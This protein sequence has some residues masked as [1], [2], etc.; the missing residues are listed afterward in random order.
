M[1]NIVI[2]KK[3]HINS[4]QTS[5]NYIN[6]ILCDYIDD[7]KFEHIKLNY[8]TVIFLLKGKMQIHYVNKTSEEVHANQ[9]Y[10]VGK[11]TVS[12]GVVKKGSEI[13]IMQFDHI[14]YDAIKVRLQNLRNQLTTKGYTFRPLEAN[15]Q[16]RIYIEQLKDILINQIDCQHYTQG[17]VNEL[18]LILQLYYTPDDLFTFCH[19]LISHASTFKETI[20]Q[21]YLKAKSLKEL[22][23]HTGMSA[24]TFN[25]KFKA[26]FN[27]SAYQWLLKQKAG[28]I[29]LRLMNESTTLSDIIREFGFH[30]HSHLQKYC[31]A[32]FHMN[33]SELKKL[34]RCNDE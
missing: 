18:F 2:Q 29:K 34:L 9:F 24:S 3:I 26:E 14:S 31:K 15:R 7:Y 19:P 20:L 27:D 5:E 22:Q 10:L 25:R 17:K 11:N 12:K 23:Q 1:R 33:P 16:M 21:H 30:S 4:L 13:L 32:H 8:Y 6:F 28:Q